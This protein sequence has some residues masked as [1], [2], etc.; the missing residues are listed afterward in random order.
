MRIKRIELN[1]SPRKCHLL[2]C[3]CEEKPVRILEW[4]KDTENMPILNWANFSI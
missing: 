1:E 4:L 2:F 3:P